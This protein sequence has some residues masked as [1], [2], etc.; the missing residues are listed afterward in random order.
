MSR[1]T[2]ACALAAGLLAATAVAGQRVGLALTAALL[3]VLA[4]GVRG[5]PSR[6]CL[7][8]TAVAAALALQPTLR[9][10]GWVV[11]AAVVACLGATAAAVTPPGRWVDVWRVLVAPLRWVAGTTLVVR[12]TRALVPSASEAPVVPVLRGVAL[13]VA[14]TAGFGALLASADRAFEDLTASLLTVHLD[15]GDALWRLVLGLAFV[16]T[17]AALA[18]SAPART[19]GPLREPWAPG[20]TELRIALGALVALFT[21]FVLVQ[22]Q[23]LFGG[24]GYVHATTGLGYGDYAR[25]GFVQLLGVAALTLGVIAVAARRRD[26]A[27]RALLGALCALTLVMLV[28][29]HHRLDLVEGAYGFSRVRYAGHAIV[30]WLGAV[31]LLTLA[32]GAHRTVARHAPRIAV[33]LTAVG[34]LA[35]C[36]SNPDARIAE[37][38]V[39]RAA[40]GGTV[41]TRYLADLSADALPALERLPPAQRA[42]VLRP[43]RARLR[44]ADGIAGWNLAR[45]RAR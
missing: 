10:A 36:L 29:A 8:L 4:A 26:G 7:W 27:V 38:A 22:L 44:R 28:S 34:A 33:G 25:Q 37:R 40:H 24:A 15:A 13:A 14:L 41:D 2:Y 45:G 35:F 12:T 39:Q 16:V 11:A 6:P 23:V 20:R 18:C 5:A 42:D 31:F 17:A 32:A 43:L 1:S 9:D 19:A 30:L 21:V 3:L